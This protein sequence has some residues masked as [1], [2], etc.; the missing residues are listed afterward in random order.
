MRVY[1]EF[2]HLYSR[3][4]YPR[5]S[6][7]MAMIL[8]PI[9]KKFAAEPRSILDLA[10]GEGTF[11]VAM[12]GRGYA[13]TGIDSSGDMLA[14]AARK[15]AESG[16][17]ADFIHGD[18]RTLSFDG[19]FDL[20]TCWF[21]SLNYLT[22][23]GDLEACYSGVF[24]SLRAGGLFIFDMNTVYGLG[25]VWQ[26]KPCEIVEDSE[27]VFEVHEKQYDFESN[28]AT[29]RIT[30]FIREGDSWMRVDEHHRERGYAL[31]EIHRALRK[32]GFEV[33]ATW[34]NPEDMTE[35]KP[36][37]GR[38]WIVAAKPKRL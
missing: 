33:L 25:V 10:C 18:M 26:K 15:A 31:V 24:K 9:L 29:M 17:K 28:I 14:L 35:P 30:G 27:E 37:S 1:G 23:D 11:A 5:F 13:V 34:D 21:D 2:A 38:V 4:D 7:Y 32:C 36:E 3:G 22:R 20:V 19:G 6:E 16:V 12:A 8:P